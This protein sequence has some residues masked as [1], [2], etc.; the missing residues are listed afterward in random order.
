MGCKWDRDAEAYLVDGERCKVDEY[1]DPTKHCAARRTC[2]AHV[3]LDELTCARCIGRVRADI[4]RIVDVAAL[5]PVVAAEAGSIHAAAASLAGPHADVR[6]W[7]D[8][9]I[10]IRAHLDTWLRLGRITEE[11]W[12]GARGR[13][14]DDDDTD[15]AMLL[16][17]WAM[18]LAEDYGLALPAKLTLTSA[19]SWLEKQ[20]GRLAQDPEQ[21]FGLLRDEMRECRRNLE[22]VAAVLAY[23]RR[24]A[25]CPTCI[26][27]GRPKPP[28][29]RLE[30]GHWCE[31]LDCE[32][33]H[34]ADDSG[35]EWVCLVDRS[36]RWTEEDYRLR[37][38]D[39]YDVASAG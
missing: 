26:E 3:G 24:G 14:E 16:P 18:M 28:R 31:S 7:T 33:V 5:M 20:L 9:R 15:P 4:R 21:D 13:E 25:P 1:G 27:G 35:D 6:A 10:A 19:A 34:Y 11:Q 8:Q 37:V 30:Y 38:A 17:R 36:H 29:L 2:S 32:K 23:R 22:A 12:L 39:V